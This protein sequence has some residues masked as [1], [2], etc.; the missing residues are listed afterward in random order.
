MKN[1]MGGRGVSATKDGPN[2]GRHTESI[3]KGQKF[4]VDYGKDHSSMSGRHE[5][6]ESIG[7]GV[8]NLSHSIA[9]ASAN[10]GPNKG[11]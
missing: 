4:S 1:S 5:R 10:Q 11:R 8:N 9:G 3:G 2:D 7:G 6:I